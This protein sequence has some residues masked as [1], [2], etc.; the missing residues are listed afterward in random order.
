MPLSRCGLCSCSANTRCLDTIRQYICDRRLR[1]AFLRRQTSTQRWS[2]PCRPRESPDQIL[3]AAS[4][5]PELPAAIGSQVVSLKLHRILLSVL[6][7]LR[8][9]EC[10]IA[11]SAHRTQVATTRP[12]AARITSPVI[13]PDSSD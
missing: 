2:T 11:K 9:P 3:P 4:Y 5:V 12:P 10:I 7:S 6:P 8:S 1:R 13:Q